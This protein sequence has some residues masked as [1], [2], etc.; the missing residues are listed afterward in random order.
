VQQSPY[1]V[2]DQVMKVASASLH[3][4][5]PTCEFLLLC[6]VQFVDVSL[7]V[8]SGPQ[9]WSCMS[10]FAVLEAEIAT[11]SCVVVCPQYVTHTSRCAS[12]CF[13]FHAPQLSAP[14]AVRTR[15]VEISHP[16]CFL[17]GFS[18]CRVCFRPIAFV[19]IA[20]RLSVPLLGLR[21]VHC[22][23]SAHRRRGSRGFDCAAAE[24][25]VHLLV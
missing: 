12:E 19:C 4:F 3:Y 11:P 8:T 24:M 25:N 14:Q 10:S 21:R 2:I 22:F 23:R 18:L 1:V 7:Q 16:N 20:I 17:N 5:H 9:V 13:I 6:Y 15:C